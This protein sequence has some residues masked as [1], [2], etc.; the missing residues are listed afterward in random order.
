MIKSDNINIYKDWK[1]V[2]KI[3]I[4]RKLEREIDAIIGK[5]IYVKSENNSS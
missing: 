1:I 5:R 3:E 4:N 2:K